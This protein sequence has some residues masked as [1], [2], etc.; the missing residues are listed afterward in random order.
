MLT[1]V[2]ARRRRTQVS[3]PAGNVSLSTTQETGSE[4]EFRTPALPGGSFFA[5][6]HD[7]TFTQLSDRGGAS[8]AIGDRWAA[9]CSEALVRGEPS[10][11]ELDAPPVLAD[12]AVRLDDI[13]EIARTAS[14]NQLQNPDFLLVGSGEAGQVLWA[15]DAKFSVDTAKSKQ[16][17]RQVVEALLEMGDTVSR[18]LPRFETDPC[19]QDGVFLCPDY[20]LT[21]RLLRDRKG[22]R[23]A[24]VREDE[25]R[26]VPVTSGGFLETMGQQGLRSFLADLDSFPFDPDA[27]L[28]VGIYYYR[29]ARAAVGCWQDQV[30]PLLTFRDTVD[31]DEEAV[32]AEAR[33]LATMR[34][35][36]WGLLLRWNDLAEE[37]RQQRSAI[38]HVTSVPVNGRQLRDTILERA[39]A[40]GVVAPSGTKV[41]RAIGSWFRGQIREEF[42]PIDPPVDDFGAM[43]DAL[44]RFSRTLTTAT[45]ARLDRIID[46][47]VALSPPIA[48]VPEGSTSIEA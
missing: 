3:I 29:L 34:T 25:V 21:H 14:R 6:I 43:L 42:G 22:P 28:M 13:P 12:V 39:E 45:E 10:L 41:R 11:L 36:A 33:R 37:V 27:R 5:A 24:T 2:I 15:A 44:G 20:P 18:L 48:D 38:D 46:E 19:V 8:N 7:R 47:M 9:L 16:V 26:Y 40:A 35:S 4:L 1:E 17:S 31:V 32:E 23:R 30:A